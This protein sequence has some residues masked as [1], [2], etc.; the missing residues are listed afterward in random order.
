MNLIVHNQ[1]A[2]AYTGGKPFDAGKPTL[3]FIHGVAND[4]SVW[5]L[6]SRYFAHHGFNSIAVDLPGHGR[7]GGMPCH[8]IGGY[9]DWLAAFLDAAGIAKASLIGHSM[10]SLIAIET[11]RQHPAKVSKLILL[12]VS[13]PMPVADALLAAAKDD[14]AT[15]YDM[16]TLWGHSTQTRLGKS[17]VPGMSLL[18]NAH[19]L[20]EQS[21]PGALY[22]DL[23]ACKEYSPDA[24]AIKKITC[25]TLVIAGTRDQMTPAKAG[26]AA[27]ALLGSAT[28][29]MLDAGHAMMSE[30]PDAV[31]AGMRRFASG[32]TAPA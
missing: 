20:I 32:A 7:S 5:Q 31:L 13:L 1:P 19:R 15:A 24:S 18:G 3:V 4:H 27:A 30:A 21:Q 17:P 2:Y 12:G 25:A 28:S 9:A 10:G 14:P 22:S 26:L 11:A 23:K 6:Q 8:S 16:L 29:V